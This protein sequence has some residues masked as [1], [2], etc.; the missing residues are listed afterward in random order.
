MKKEKFDRFIKEAAHVIDVA[1][2]DLQAFFDRGQEQP[3]EGGEWLFHESTP[4]NWAGFVLEG[5]VTITRGLHGA[6]K[7]VAVLGRGALISESALLDESPHSTGAFTREG[8]LIWLIPRD[9][10]DAFREEK[11]EIFYRL[12]ARVARRISE[13]LRAVSQQLAGTDSL[14][15]LMEG[16]RL[17]H[18]SLGERELPN[19]GLLRGPDP[20]R[21]G[22]LRHFRC[23]PEKF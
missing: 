15:E 3:Y 12:V 7:Q 1:R 4:R 23:A 17:E 6:S 13:R 19:T 10:I 9:K 22:E 8:A 18:D 5:E 2:K 20:A 21:G 14:Q 16:V 11:P